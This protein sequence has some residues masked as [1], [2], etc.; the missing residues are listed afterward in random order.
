MNVATAVVFYDDNGAELEFVGGFSD[1][2]TINFAGDKT[3][4]VSAPSP[5]TALNTVDITS[6]NGEKF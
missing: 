3:V 2:R 1:E 5:N 4:T 6:T